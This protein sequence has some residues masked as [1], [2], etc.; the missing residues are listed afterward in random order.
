MSTS[1]RYFLKQASAIA[2]GFSGLHHFVGAGMAR[3]AHR[4][5]L[6]RSVR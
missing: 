2:L 6:G 5:P 1:R 3:P 4:H